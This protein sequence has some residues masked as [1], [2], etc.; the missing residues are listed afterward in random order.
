MKTKKI[1]LYISFIPYIY[2]LINI[3]YVSLFGYGYN[4]GQKAY[5]IIAIGNWL[6]DF[7]E[8]FLFF[9]LNL[10]NISFSFCIIY[11]FFYLINSFTTR[12]ESIK[13]EKNSKAKFDISKGI[14]IVTLIL[15]ILLILY[16]IYSMTFGIEQIQICFGNCSKNIV[17]G[18]D[19]FYQFLFILLMLCIIPIIPTIVIYDLIYIIVRKKKGF[20]LIK[21]D[22]IN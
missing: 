13:E 2:L 15:W 5:S 21:K 16:L 11:Q 19:A 3:I 14:F 8:S 20:N 10:I 7:K 6:S 4:L 17:Y 12:K 22:T 1:I 18:L 9:E